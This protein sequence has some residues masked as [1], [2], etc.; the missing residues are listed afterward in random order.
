MKVYLLRHG[1]TAYNDEHRYQGLR[2]IPLSPAG[3][4][5]L[6][7]ADLSPSVVWV[8]PL[9]RA[10]RTAAILF[11]EVRQ[12][13]VPGLREMDFGAFEGRNYLEMAHDP[14]YRGWVDGNCEGVCPGGE[15]RAMFC[16]RVCGAFAELLKQAERKQELVIVAHGGVQM[17]VLERFALPRRDYFTWNAPCGGGYLLETDESKAGQSGWLRLLDT[18]C[19]TRSSGKG[20]AEC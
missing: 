8:S 3:E 15:S 5:E 12:E 17:A 4:A 18:V 14:V 7:R 1:R 2:D 16:G 20:G 13:I 19:Y 10:R 9:I 11:P 6:V